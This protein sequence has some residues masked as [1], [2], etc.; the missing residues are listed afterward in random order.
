MS[1]IGA[2]KTTI[3]PDIYCILRKNFKKKLLEI[4]ITGIEI[5]QKQDNPG[6]KEKV[7]SIIDETKPNIKLTPPPYKKALKCWWY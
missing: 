2:S 4:L 5:T 1:E 6:K 7:D 3:L